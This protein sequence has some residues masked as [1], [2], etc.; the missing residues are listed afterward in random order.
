MHRSFRPL[1]LILTAAL[2]AI[3]LGPTALADGPIPVSVVQDEDGW[4]LERGGEPFFIKGGCIVRNTAADPDLIRLL[5]ELQAAGGNAIRLWATGPGTMSILDAA[6]ERGIAVMLGLWME[7]S[8][9]HVDSDGG[10]FDYLDPADVQAQLASLI[11]QVNLYKNHPA[12]LAWG[13][14][15]ELE[16]LDADTDADQELVTAIWTAIN[17]AAGIIKVR[18][19]LHPTISVTADLGEWHLVDNATQLATYC[20]NIDIWGVNAYETLSQIRAKIDNGPWD[21]PYLVPEYGPSGWWG[22]GQTPWGGRIEHNS[23]VKANWYR[24]GWI[25]SIEGQSD[26]CLGGFVYLWDDL[27]PPTDTW[28]L[29]FGPAGERSSCVD[30]MIEVWSGTPPANRV[31]E[32]SGISG[33]GSMTFLPYD[34]ATAT[35]GVSDPDGDDIVVDWILGSE[36]FD[37]SGVYLWQFSPNCTYLEV[38]GDAVLE[39]EM[40]R[41]PGAYRLVAIAR[42]PQGGIALA[43]TPFFVDGDLPDDVQTMPFA[44]DDHYGPSGY[45]G[46]SWTLTGSGMESPN[47]ACAG[48]GHRFVFNPPQTNLWAGVAWQYPDYNWGELPGLPIMP[49]AESV[50]FYAWSDVPGTVLDVFVGTEGSDG[51]SVGL[52]DLE[53]P[54]EPTLFSIPL[55][56]IEYEDVTIPFGWTISN[57]AANTMTR[58]INIADLR[59]IGPPPPPPC[60]GDFDDDRV[61]GGGDLGLLIARWYGTQ[62]GEF[63]L[64][65]DGFVD[66]QDLTRL[67]T[68]WGP[69]PE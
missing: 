52:G 37:E 61:V 20:P 26:R 30:A 12:V 46:A 60:P 38:G 4:H 16:H 55:D 27:D 15:N 25:N 42:D 33:V 23:T 18:D 48:V 44:I 22:A 65:G 7:H 32:V 62:A 39:F 13:V 10:N 41:A 8:A 2:L 11:A 43:T 34:P 40:P 31:P 54:L 14:G 59:W 5:D 36:I 63:D 68:L 29:M 58:T 51:F 1:V 28:F 3:L 69:C 67:F 9:G 35:L 21:R 45:M 6:H 19:P 57:S 17:S 66:G 53:L 47:G 56:G 50:D 24:N 64:N 49:G